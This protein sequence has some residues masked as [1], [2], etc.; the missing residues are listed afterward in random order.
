MCVWVNSIEKMYDQV[1]KQQ[2]LR[3]L[4]HTDQNSHQHHPNK[5]G[6]KVVQDE[7]GGNRPDT[8]YSFTYSTQAFS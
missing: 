5:E 8:F 1:D 6:F 3:K 4:I 7:A 2:E